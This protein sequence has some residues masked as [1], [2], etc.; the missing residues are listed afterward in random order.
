MIRP[1]RRE[2]LETCAAVVRESFATVAPQYGITRESAPRHTSFLPARRLFDQYDR[3]EP[4]YLYE[5]EG[6]AA[7]YCSMSPGGE[8]GACEL[9][10]L[11]VL[12]ACRHLGI[13][14]ALVDHA[15]REARAMGCRKMEISII[16]EN[17]VLKNWYQA[18]GFVPVRTQK[19]DFFPFTCG[20][21]E[22]AL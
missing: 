5:Y 4:M 13:G 12:P 8:E 20:Y 1:A 2:E 14:K 17:T 22:L 7:G 18:Q 21:L 10:H 11:A 16:E 3:G 6:R 9:N 15:V 19:F